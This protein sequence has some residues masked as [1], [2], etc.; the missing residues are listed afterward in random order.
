[1]YTRVKYVIYASCIIVFTSVLTIV[2][3]DFFTVLSKYTKKGC[4]VLAVA[5]R[6]IQVK[7]HRIDKLNRYFPSSSVLVYC[8]YCTDINLVC[9]DEVECDLTLLGLLIM[10]NKLKPETAPIIGIL[11]SANIR[12]VMVTGM[13]CYVFYFIQSIMCFC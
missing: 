13:F 5:H 6:S 10:Q 12:T 3:S 4:R 8:V 1:M 7:A 11:H 9:R 2:P